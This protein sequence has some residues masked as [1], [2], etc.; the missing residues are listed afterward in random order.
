[1][2]SRLSLQSSDSVLEPPEFSLAVLVDVDTRSLKT[3]NAQ[4][5]SERPEKGFRRR[6][7]RFV[8]SAALEA[9]V[10]LCVA[11]DLTLTILTF[12]LPAK[13]A[14]S[15]IFFLFSAVFLFILLGDV[16]LRVIKDGRI[17]FSKPLN[18][19]EFVV[20]IAGAVTICLDGANRTC[21]GD[22]C[23]SSGGGN[24]SG[25]SLGRSVR[26][27]LRIARVIRGFVQVIA[28]RGGLSGSIDRTTD[29]VMDS[30][31]RQWL[32]DMCLVPPENVSM[33]PSLG[34]F[35]IE[36]TQVRSK[37]FEALH[38]PFTVVG[39]VIDF[40]H[41][42]VDLMAK[43]QRHSKHISHTGHRLLIVVEN[44]LLVF[45][46]GHH[47]EPPAPPWDF[48]TVVAN[49]RK[50]V[51]LVMGRLDQIWSSG[52]EAANTPDVTP[53]F[54]T[55]KKSFGEYFKR[56]AAGLA[57]NVLAHGIHVSFGNLEIRFED[58]KSELSGCCHVPS[59]VACGVQVDSLQVRALGAKFGDTHEEA[60]FRARGKWQSGST[61]DEELNWASMT[62]SCL[63]MEARKKKRNLK[64]GCR[65]A[66]AIRGVGAFWDLHEANAT[67]SAGGR[68]TEQLLEGNGVDLAAFLRGFARTR[69]RERLRMAICKEA[70]ARLLQD[71]YDASSAKM[72]RLKR[73]RHRI[74]GHRYLV[75]P[76]GA[77]LHAVVRSHGNNLDKMKG[78]IQEWWPPQ[79]DVDVHAPAVALQ[80]DLLQA[81]SIV[82]LLDY[83][84]RW[85]WEDQRI[86]SLPMDCCDSFVKHRWRYALR[87]V[88]H[89]IDHSY[90]WHSLTFVEMRRRASLRAEYLSA[91]C[92]ER[93]LNKKR[94]EVLQVA[95]PLADVFLARRA[96]AVIVAQQ[97]REQGKHRRS[98]NCAHRCASIAS[99][100]GLSCCRRGKR[101]SETEE[102]E[103]LHLQSDRNS[104]QWSDVDKNVHVIDVDELEN[105]LL[106]TAKRA[107]QLHLNVDCVEVDVLQARRVQDLGAARVQ[108]VHFEVQF[109]R[110]VGVQ[111]APRSVWKRHAPLAVVKKVHDGGGLPSGFAGEA[112]VRDVLAVWCAA[113]STAP[114]LRRMLRCGW[115][116]SSKSSARISDVSTSMATAEGMPIFMESGIAM[117]MRVAEM[118]GVDQE[119]L[120]GPLPLS[121]GSRRGQRSVTEDS[122]GLSATGALVEPPSWQFAACL[123]QLEVH[124]CETFF[125]TILEVAKRRPLLLPRGL[126]ADQSSLFW[127]RVAQARRVHIERAVRRA[128]IVR[129]AERLAGITGVLK[130]QRITGQ[131]FFV[132][133]V[134][135]TKLKSYS[136]ANWLS[137]HVD[138]PRGTLELDRCV[139]PTRLKLGFRSSEVC[140]TSAHVRTHD[141]WWHETEAEANASIE[142]QLRNLEMG[143]DVV[144]AGGPVTRKSTPATAASECSAKK[145]LV[146]RKSGVASNLHSPTQSRFSSANTDACQDLEGQWRADCSLRRVASLRKP[147]V[148]A[149]GLA[150]QS[151]QTLRLSG[152]IA[153]GCSA[154][155]HNPCGVDCTSVR[156]AQRFTSSIV[157]GV[158]PA[159]RSTSEDLGSYDQGQRSTEPSQEEAWLDAG[160]SVRMDVLRP[161]RVG[162]PVPPRAT[163][164][165]SALGG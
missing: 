48:E 26:P 116:M 119:A 98:L 84:R 108:L 8:D 17:F 102:E 15:T 41:I 1:M 111:S 55:S 86:M 139:L 38:L 95:L 28:T 63:G 69:A 122:R 142:A 157:D 44:V 12:V 61:S 49:K 159:Q 143:I 136:K 42:D 130:D 50:L 161:E 113:P 156:P 115:T 4:W 128:R 154:M 78:L 103:E 7:Q 147:N 110:A 93:P 121:P 52:V 83:C 109:M 33:K 75:A 70:E 134:K 36:K 164:Q 25:A 96:A 54:Q 20:C 79:T 158:R 107:T 64:H 57:A 120:R 131:V 22:S 30:I 100:T 47:Q 151:S 144:G 39:G 76:C 123:L 81:R 152:S 150:P 135:A 2:K 45:G 155:V 74:A 117:Q 59:A 118:S 114:Q 99:H 16:I 105:V 32:G 153:T 27:A 141:E 60:E 129:R 140:T 146:S 85:Y 104:M 11:A 124:V 127:E 149:L 67:A 138:V 132:G 56:R 13:D 34:Q 24:K 3:S 19:L 133:G 87:Q 6:I 14:D 29:R 46:P 80:M 21:Q 125:R 94:I 77:S 62:K 58:A 126:A 68:Y 73:L 160:V 53:S 89:S 65:A 91:L 51:D 9:I 163:A 71:S 106:E 10:S 101:Q 92:A 35:H 43:T 88:L 137:Y 72:Q 23:S 18:W 66:V 148:S 145:K 31:I 165:W 5:E 37:A 82:G 97:Q 112:S 40:V 90:M 162:L